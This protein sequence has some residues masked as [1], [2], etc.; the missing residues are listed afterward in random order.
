MRVAAGLSTEV[1]VDD[2]SS[3][4]EEVD[5]PEIPKE[6]SRFELLSEALGLGPAV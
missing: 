5:F 1:R 3:R 6:E 2:H 4:E